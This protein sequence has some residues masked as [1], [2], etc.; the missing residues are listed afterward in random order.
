M[1]ELDP[2]AIFGGDEGG[3]GDPETAPAVVLP[4]PLEATVSYGGGTAQGPAALLR[5][6]GELE[7]VEEETGTPY[8]SR[9]EV[10]TLPA[11]S[12][13][14]GGDDAARRAAIER[15]EAAARPP[16]E[17]GAFL[18]TLGG[19][20]AISTAP[21]RAAAARHPGLGIVGVDA[22]LDLR[23][24]YEGS[25]WSH[26]CVLRRI[27][28]EFGP[29]VLWVGARSLAAEERDFLTDHPEIDVRWAHALDG[30]DG[31]AWM[32]EAIERL[33]ETIYLTID[34]DGLDPAVMPGTGTPEPGGLAYRTVL[35]VVRELA[36]RRRI[37]AADIVELAPLPGQQVSEFT[38]AKLA[39]KLIS[40]VLARRDRGAP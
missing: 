12:L 8:W 6:S 38:A 16:I 17:R 9:G 37:V 35:R 22:H 14:P 1:S 18:L 24:R 32:I 20:H 15:I 5:A 28:E 39:A 3:G 33:P 13:T 19:E 34:V 40:A 2:R 36:A 10:A 27:V 23:D 30:L 7:F 21:F 29:P 25:P 26:A 11:L 31:D 4:A